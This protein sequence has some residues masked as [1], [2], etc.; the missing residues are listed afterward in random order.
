M[1]VYLNGFGDPTTR[2]DVTVRRALAYLEAGADGIFV[3]GVTDPATISALVERVPAP[4]NILVGPGAPSVAELGRLGVARISVGSKLALA[5]YGLVRRGAE[6]LLRT[7]GYGTLAGGLAYDEVNAL[8]DREAG[9][10]TDRE[11]GRG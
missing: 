9:R 11:A 3:P 10:D 1:D 6:E 4:L 7:G 2:L 8:L 5:A